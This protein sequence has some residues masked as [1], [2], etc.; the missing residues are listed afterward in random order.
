MS[1]NKIKSITNFSKNLKPEMIKDRDE[2]FNKPLSVTNKVLDKIIPLGQVKTNIIN[3][4]LF[5]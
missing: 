4:K 3:L 5:D 2:N 1:I